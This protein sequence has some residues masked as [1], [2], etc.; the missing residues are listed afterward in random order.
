MEN[1]RQSLYNHKLNRK[2][3]AKERKNR[4]AG[5]QANQPVSKNVPQVRCDWDLN[6][7]IKKMA[8]ERFELSTL[9]V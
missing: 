1:N 6:P 7:N 3:E 8:R 2:I 4:S 9:R 5:T